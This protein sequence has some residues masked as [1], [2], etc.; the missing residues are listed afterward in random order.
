M[1]SYIYYLIAHK[2][3]APNESFALKIAPLEKSG[4]PK[5]GKVISVHSDEANQ[6]FNEANCYRVRIGKHPSNFHYI[7]N[8]SRYTILSCSKSI[9]R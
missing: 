6:L 1:Y 5:K 7:Y 9:W 3:D 8:S 2:E 4:K